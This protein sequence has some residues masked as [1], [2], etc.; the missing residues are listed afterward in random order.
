MIFSNSTIWVA[1]S[2]CRE[3]LKYRP[4]PPVPYRSPTA[5]ELCSNEHWS[6]AQNSCPLGPNRQIS[7][8]NS[9]EFDDV[10]IGLTRPLG[11]T[12][13][14]L[15]M[16]GILKSIISQHIEDGLFFLTKPILLRHLRDEFQCVL[17]VYFV[18]TLC[19][20]CV[21]FV[22]TS[23]VVWVDVSLIVNTHWKYTACQSPIYACLSV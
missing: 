11:K 20:L 22:R 3:P 9:G 8:L 10:K 1:P 17:R 15:G 14:Q 12:C 21:Y 19:I 6:T 7:L 23:G 18:C 13:D 16:V 2:R 4:N 5:I